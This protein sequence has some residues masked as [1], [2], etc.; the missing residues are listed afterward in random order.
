MPP[1]CAAS[2]QA[3]YYRTVAGKWQVSGR[4]AATDFDEVVKLDKEYMDKCSLFYDI[5]IILKTIKVVILRTG[6]L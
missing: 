6:A 2:Q 4:N 3:W 5:N 1:F